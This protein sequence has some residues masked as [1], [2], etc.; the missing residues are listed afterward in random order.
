MIRW[1][2][3]TETSKHCLHNKLKFRELG[4]ERGNVSCGLAFRISCLYRLCPYYSK[5]LCS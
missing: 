3:Q 4:G 1:I 5:L 2:L